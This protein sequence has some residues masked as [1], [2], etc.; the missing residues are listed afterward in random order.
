MCGLGLVW[1]SVGGGRRANGT[2]AVGGSLSWE[3]LASGEAVG[4]MMRLA[5]T[6]S[7]SQRMAMWILRTPSRKAQGQLLG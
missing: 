3:M 1:L 5:A 6:C 4:Q 7:A 2:L